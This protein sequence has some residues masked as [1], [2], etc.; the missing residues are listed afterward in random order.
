MSRRVIISVVVGASL[1]IAVIVLAAGS[2]TYW[3]GLTRPVTNAD[4]ARAICEA[5]VK[6]DLLA[7]TNAS[8]RDVY[9]KMDRL[10]EDDNVGLGTDAA[11]VKEVWAVGGGV[12]SPGTSG[13]IPQSH[14]MCR[15]YMFDG[16]PPRTRVNFTDADDAGKRVI[17]P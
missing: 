5:A 12:E 11:R 15:T 3:F 16:Q 4:P 13:E 8:F 17:R 1:V 9:V 2:M 14:F 10:S 7:P 6:H